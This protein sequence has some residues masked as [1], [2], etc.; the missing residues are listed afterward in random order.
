M[1]DNHYTSPFRPSSYS[2][3]II[4]SVVQQATHRSVF[5]REIA[6]YL[7]VAIYVLEA[8]APLA[9]FHVESE[10]SGA[11]LFLLNKA[12]LASPKETSRWEKFFQEHGLE[13]MSI[14]SDDGGA[15]AQLERHLS[16]MLEAKHVA[17]AAKGI[18]ETTLRCVVL[19]V[20]NTGKST[21]INRLTG[22]HRARTG[23]RPGITRG[24]QWIRILEGVDLLDTPGILRD[25]AR[26][27][28]GRHHLLALGLIP[29]DSSV[30]EGALTAVFTRLGERGLEKLS[31]FYH[32]DIKEDT[33]VWEA[34]DAVGRRV[35]GSR[36]QDPL[37]DDVGYKILA[38]FRHCRF[39]LVTLETVHE[40]GKKLAELLGRLE[41]ASE[42]PGRKRK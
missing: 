25:Y 24:Y 10:L 35:L 8:R 4:L 27:K 12:D 15:F 11:R 30:L 3:A 37:M 19:G 23:N 14:D 6:A 17:R 29:E 1:A 31:R 5:P 7:D 22:T 40:Y 2:R 33:P 26:F 34:V 42:T 9:T 13:A 28:Q 38:D 18:R 36:M 32:V 21:I 39:G 20:P 16:D 41:A